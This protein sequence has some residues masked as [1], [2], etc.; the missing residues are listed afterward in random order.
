MTTLSRRH[1]GFAATAGA[2]GLMAAACSS[3]NS[4]GGDAG[5]SDA[6]G[7][8]GTVTVED[9]NGQ[10]T[11][12]TPPTSVVATDNNSFQ[13]LSD[14]GVSLTAASRALMPTTI[15]YKDD[16]S[17]VDLGN[18]REPNLEAVVAVEPDLIITGSRFSQYQDDFSSLAPDAVVLD[19]DARD[20]QPF[21]AELKRRVDV[22]GTIFGK[23][24]EATALGEDLDASIARVKAAYDAAQKVMS[25][26]VSGGEIGYSA[27]HVG[28]TF[29]PMY[30]VL[31]LT[32]ALEVQGA[33]DDH[34]GDDIS[35]EAIAD[36]NPDWILVMDRDAA[37]ASEDSQPAAE[38]IE[39]SEA[40][41]NV[42]AVT[43]GHVVYMPDDTYTNEGIETYTEFFGSFADALE[44]TS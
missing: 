15:P 32:P 24:K 10:H 44:A 34:Q 35:V 2:L 36:S 27:P 4:T 30:D 14:W 13:T 7:T 20:D 12:A 29:G 40:L 8:A 39:G 9:N 25:V 38:V 28:R 6:G 5:A 37:V 3:D 22:L 33:D 41:K 21:E 42:T 18:H 31:G 26:I 16:E 23:E 43:A 17:I 11:V 1:F 19:L